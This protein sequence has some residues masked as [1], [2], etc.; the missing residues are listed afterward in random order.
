MIKD[1][2]RGMNARQEK[3]YRVFKLCNQ[4]MIREVPPHQRPITHPHQCLN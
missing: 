3:K 1:L 2:L 4:A